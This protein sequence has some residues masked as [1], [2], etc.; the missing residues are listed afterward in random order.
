MH[1]DTGTRPLAAP[2]VY[3]YNPSPSD[4]GTRRSSWCR[5]IPRLPLPAPLPSCGS[6]AR[7]DLYVDK[8]LRCAAPGDGARRDARQSAG[9]FPHGVN[10]NPWNL[11]ASTAEWA[12]AWD[13]TW[14]STRLRPS[15]TGWAAPPATTTAPRP[16]CSTA[17]LM[18]PPRGF[19]ILG[20][21]NLHRDPA[22]RRHELLFS[23]SPRPTPHPH[24]TSAGRHPADI[25]ASLTASTPGNDS[26]TSGRFEVV[27]H[28]TPDRLLAEKS[29]SAQAH[30][31]QGPLH[32]PAPRP[33]SP[34]GR[35]PRESCA[36]P[37]VPL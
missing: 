19:A 9:P 20:R 10:G 29:S 7:A 36:H 11:A 12:E 24:G 4:T 30:R 1:T 34:T 33:L 17:R 6:S 26:R 35:A 13:P 3:P 14:P 37:G 8:L 28:T 2:A 25:T 5:V 31:G 27:H 23:S 32:G 16:L 18:R 22:R 15:S 21:R